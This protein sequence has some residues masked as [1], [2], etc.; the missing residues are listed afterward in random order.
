[1]STRSIRRMA[2]RTGAPLVDG[3]R[4][5]ALPRPRGDALEQLA[6]LERLLGRLRSDPVYPER[7]SRWGWGQRQ[8]VR[9]FSKIASPYKQGP[10]APSKAVSLPSLLA[11]IK[12]RAPARVR[13]CV[14]RKS[15]KEVLFAKGV[16]GRRGRSPGPYRRKQSSYYS[17]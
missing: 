14:Q 9:V 13:F 15:R 6:H 11:S 4:A 5:D 12:M 7:Y 8:G 2:R 1:M 16:A 17:C 10:Q 3:A